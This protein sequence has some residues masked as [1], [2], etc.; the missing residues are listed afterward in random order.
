MSYDFKHILVPVDFSD[1][2]EKSVKAALTIFGQAEKIT[3]LTIAEKISS[4]HAELM[5]EVDEMMAQATKERMDEFCSKFANENR[6][7][8]KLIK[9]GSPAHQIIVTAEEN[10]VDLIVMG[11]QGR[12]AL[13]RV[14]LGSTSYDVARKAPCSVFILRKK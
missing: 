4:R 14:F 8:Q 13:A 11:G 2:S 3:L 10:D 5:T 9:R 1:H 7:I 6:N 12:N